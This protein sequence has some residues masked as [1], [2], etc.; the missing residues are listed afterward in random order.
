MNL[1]KTTSNRI[2]FKN[3][4]KDMLFCLKAIKPRLASVSGGSRAF[5]QGIASIMIVMRERFHT[6]GD[7]P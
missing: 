6:Q 5:V 3:N 2:N 1:R 7:Y 4:V